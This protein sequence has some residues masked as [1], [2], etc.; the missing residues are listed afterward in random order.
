MEK[1]ININENPKK[2]SSFLKI[3]E[4]IGN[5]MPHPLLLFI[6][7]S[8]IVVILS[9][10][11]NKMGVYAISPSDGSKIEINNLLTLKT[12]IEFI[13]NF[14]GNFQSFPIL[15]IVLILTMASGFAE[16]VGFFKAMINMYLKDSRGNKVIFIAAFVGSMGN[17][18]GDSA[19]LVMPL[20]LAT[21][22][23]G[24]KRNPIAGL[25]LGYAAVGG[26]FGVSVIPNGFDAILTPISLTAARLIDPSF[27]MTYMSGYY[28]TFIGTFVVALTSTFVT[29]K[30]IE[31]R[32]GEYVAQEKIE[33]EEEITLEKK[34]A[35][36]KALLGILVFI[37][38]IVVLCIPKTSPFRSPS[39]SL[40]IGSPL[41][42]SIT[43]LVA[44]FFFIPAYI[45][46]KATKQINNIKELANILGDNVKGLAPFIVLAVIISQFLYLF[47]ISNVGTVL[48]IKGGELLNDLKV[49]TPIVCVLFI[50]L[51]AV[52]NIFIISGSVKYLILGPIFIPMFMQLGINPAFTQVMYRLADGI[53]LALSPLNAFFIILLGLV[54]KYNK[55]IGIGSI[56]SYM[57]PYTIAYFIVMTCLI[58]LWYFLGIA[59][60]VGSSILL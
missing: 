32:L 59:P 38:L 54:Q 53:T 15:A 44:L 29:V 55:D 60:G 25:L 4:T 43:M 48:A 2:E 1:S 57:I 45:Y 30:Y 17:L 19:F 20:I 18:F 27:D 33:E 13:K 36:K 24:V 39:G 9:F 56:F 49:P 26:G 10:I 42:S 52:I 12:L 35:V 37:V 50:I 31:P 22:F 28:L 14:I 41:M 23:K 47:S 3:I 6:Y 40:V 11:L 21:I 58:L 46:S 34:M 5:K 51:V 8:L 7:I 16:K